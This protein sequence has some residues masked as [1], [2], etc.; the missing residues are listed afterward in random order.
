MSYDESFVSTASTTWRNRLA[1]YETGHTLGPNHRVSPVNSC[2]W[3]SYFTTQP[4]TSTTETRSMRTT[5][6]MRI[7]NRYAAPSC[8]LAC[9]FAS[10]VI[11][12]GSGEDTGRHETAHA[13]A[14]V[15]D[16]LKTRFV[17]PI[18]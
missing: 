17:V 8:A 1:C 15:I 14:Y 2:M 4:P 7:I 12:C 13:R 10:S 16:H 11:G 6:T 3:D 18:R 5:E 9:V